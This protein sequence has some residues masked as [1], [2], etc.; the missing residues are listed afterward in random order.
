M[1]Q[2]RLFSYCRQE[3]AMFHIIFTDLGWIFLRFHVD[4]CMV[5]LHLMCISMKLIPYLFTTLVKI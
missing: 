4:V 2:L 5:V 1:R 3:N